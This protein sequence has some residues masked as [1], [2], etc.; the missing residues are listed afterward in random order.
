MKLLTARI[1][2]MHHKRFAARSAVVG[3]ALLA[4]VGFSTANADDL[5]PAHVPAD[6]KWLIHV[7]FASLSDSA[8]WQKLRKERPEMTQG[9]RDWMKNQYGINPPKDLKSLT[10]FSR[11]YRPYTGTVIVQAQYEA[12]KIKAELQEAKDHQTTQWN[13]QTLHTFTKPNPVGHKQSEHQRSGQKKAD[14]R[15]SGRHEMTVVMVDQNTILLASSVDSAKDTLKLLAGE[16]DSLKG[17]D[18][19]LLTDKKEAAWVYAAA[20]NLSKLEDHPVAMPII[21]QHKQINW[22]FGE[23]SD[24]MLYEQA[25]LVAQSEQIA[26]DMETVLNGI[27]AWERLWAE[28]S[29]PMTALMQN[30]RVMRDGDTTG[31]EWKGQS[32]QVVAAMDDLFARLETWKPIMMKHR[33]VRMQLKQG[34]YPGQGDSQKRKN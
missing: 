32:D 33:Q 21:A 30:V 20:T 22:S 14:R 5:N 31:F 6:A 18:S 8:T 12:S 23:Q 4:I 11:E 15:S 26:K 7:D 16:S 10:M 3:L 29:K 2:K 34:D 17:K 27:V 25:K 13:D 24:G 1:S 19:P 28:G 9:V